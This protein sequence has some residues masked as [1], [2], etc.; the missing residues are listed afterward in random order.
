MLLD[1]HVQPLLCDFGLTKVWDSDYASSTTM[2][3]IGSW[4]WMSPELLEGSSKSRKSDV[5]ALG[6]LIVE[7]SQSF[8]HLLASLLSVNGVHSMREDL[9]WKGRVP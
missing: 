7:V 1:E 9:D 3:G 8:L 5:F 6:M 4:R 2:T